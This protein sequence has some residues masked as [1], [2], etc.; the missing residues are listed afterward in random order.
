MSA[1][2]PS[3]AG[4]GVDAQRATFPE[5]EVDLDALFVRHRER[6]RRLLESIVAE[7]SGDDPF[8]LPLSEYRRLDADAKAEVV[9]RAAILARDRVDEAFRAHGAAWIVLVEGELVQT[10]A[11]PYDLPTPEAVLA[12]GA[13]RDRVAFLFEAPLIEE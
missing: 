5:M 6:F 10:S 8:T 2:P 3:T 13:P 7:E 11:V 1:R 12:L 9:R 4:G